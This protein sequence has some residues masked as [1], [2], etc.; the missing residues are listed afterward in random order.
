MVNGQLRWYDLCDA[1]ELMTKLDRIEEKLD[2]LNEAVHNMH[3]EH[4]TRIAN[5]ETVQKGFIS[6]VVIVLTALITSVF[7]YIIPSK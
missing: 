7:S 4:T 5:V 6:T 2:K 3:V 1:D